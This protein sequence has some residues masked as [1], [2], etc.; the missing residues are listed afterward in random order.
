MSA[1]GTAWAKAVTAN[2]R[3][4]LLPSDE[5]L[6]MALGRLHSTSSNKAIASYTTLREATRDCRRT[7]IAAANRLADFGLIEKSRRRGPK[8]RQGANEYF[9][10]M[11]VSR[12]QPLHSGGAIPECNEQTSGLVQPLHSGKSVQSADLHHPT[13]ARARSRSEATVFGSLRV[14]GGKS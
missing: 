13:R 14:V 2:S 8:G 11:G 9:L 6:L 7:V 4:H 1:L 12:V 5:R 10:K 3:P